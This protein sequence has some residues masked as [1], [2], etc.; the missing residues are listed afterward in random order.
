MKRHVF[1]LFVMAAWRVFA[2]DEPIQMRPVRAATSDLSFS[3]EWDMDTEAISEIRVDRVTRGSE[4]ERVGVRLGDRLVSIDGVPVVTSKRGAIISR[5]G[6][7]T[8]KERLTFSGHRG[9]FR[10]KWTITLRL[11]P[12]GRVEVIEEKP[13]PL[14]AAAAARD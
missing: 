2:A 9:L 3:I 7:M 6:G 1:M 11:S 10:K 13:N 5:L 4:V 14:S 12:T 8:G